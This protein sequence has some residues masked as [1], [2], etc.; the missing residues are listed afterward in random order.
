M[1][2][3]KREEGH[4]G[5]STSQDAVDKD[6][7][8]SKAIVVKR[9][10]EFV[11]A[12]HNLLDVTPAESFSVRGSSDGGEGE[13]ATDDKIVIARV[14]RKMRDK[15]QL[16]WIDGYTRSG[17]Q[18]AE[19]SKLTSPKC[20]TTSLTSAMDQLEALATLQETAKVLEESE[21]ETL[22]PPT[23]PEIR[24]AELRRQAFTHR[25]YA[26]EHAPH[27]TTRADVVRQH[28]E[29]L[30]FLGDAVLYYV[31]TK[32]LYVKFPD[33]RE[34]E[35][36][37]LRAELIGNHT[38]QEFGLEYALQDRLLLSD[39]AQNEQNVRANPKV[40]ADTF[41]AY[42][43]ALLLDGHDG[44]RRCLHWLAR[45]MRPKIQAH[46]GS[47][48]VGE[49]DP[50]AKQR[51]FN[52]FGR[53]FPS[54]KTDPRYT[55]QRLPLLSLTYD[56]VDGAGGNQGGFVVACQISVV[57]DHHVP[58]TGTTAEGLAETNVEPLTRGPVELGR[59]W[60]PNKKEAEH[61]AAM[62]ACKNFGL[63]L[64]PSPLIHP[65]HLPNVGDGSAPALPP[66]PDDPLDLQ[67]QIGANSTKCIRLTADVLAKLSTTTLY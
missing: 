19:S 39:A 63:V 13:G 1:G 14:L 41:E 31:T 45:L 23:L 29:R 44:P 5:M 66:Y 60:G 43:G 48:E 12:L 51:I 38:G 15:G 20:P 58:V 11:N 37:I 47:A 7:G 18:T 9:L 57:D 2:K 40:I 3:R 24:D 25:S 55:R 30:E 10:D 50:S 54:N 26:F 16:T 52:H 32:L 59:G 6:F 27:G 22:W 8:H 21:N 35:L 46:I 4:P 53:H 64:D 49:V 61:R 17:E 62:D 33:A 34:G 67:S 65:P 28:N 42:L 56:W 36:S